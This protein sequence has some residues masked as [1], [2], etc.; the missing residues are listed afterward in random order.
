MSKKNT[1]N[2]RKKAYLYLLVNA[3]C[4]GAALVIVKPALEFTT[5]FRFLFYRYLVAGIVFS[6]PYLYKKRKQLS[7][8]PLKKIVAL[9][10]LG[11]VLSLTILYYG[12]AQTSA[13]E[14]SLIGTTGPVFICL[15]GILLLKEK[16]ER[17][18]WL[19]LLL[20]LIGSVLIV[21]THNGLNNEISLQGNLFVLTFNMTNALYFV[22]A[23]K[24]YHPLD[25]TMVGAI[26]FMVGLFGFLIINLS[27]VHGDFFRLITQ[28]AQDWTQRSVQIASI[29]MGIFG[30]VIG[31]I[32]YIQGQDKIE[33]SEASLFAYLQPLI[34]LPLGILLLGETVYGQQIIGLGV[35]FLGVLLA[36]KRI[37]R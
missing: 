31:L 9:E 25:K 10:L 28:I 24:Y 3:L 20:S 19:G 7:Q 29:Y 5:P 6:L 35:V 32:S 1:Q 8:I 13:I 22:L 23:K 37:H 16:Q 36:E 34:Y 27:L 11:T 17:W 26:S 2:R 33:A 14:A 21:T 4:W 12:L 18:E 15:A 30:S